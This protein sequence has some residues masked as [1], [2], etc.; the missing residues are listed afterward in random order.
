MNDV[1]C[2][3]LQLSRE[4][5]IRESI[6]GSA[7]YSLLWLQHIAPISWLQRPEAGSRDRSQ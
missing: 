7:L 3:C 6:Q 4:I 1:C 2:C 5:V